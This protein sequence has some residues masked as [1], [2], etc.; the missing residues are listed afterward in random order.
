MSKKFILQDSDTV[1]YRGKEHGT[2]EIGTIEFLKS[3]PGLSWIYYAFHAKEKDL[4]TPEE[5]VAICKDIDPTWKGEEFSLL[6]LR[7]AADANCIS[8]K[9]NL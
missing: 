6:I 3:Q 9:M 7:E 1:I 4:L 8:L 5:I 2:L